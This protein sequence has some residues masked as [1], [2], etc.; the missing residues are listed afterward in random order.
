ML[1]KIQLFGSGVFGQVGSNS[2]T[3]TSS[4]AADRTGLAGGAAPG[5]WDGA[6]AEHAAASTVDTITTPMRIQ[7]APTLIAFLPW[8]LPGRALHADVE[9]APYRGEVETLAV[10]IPERHARGVLVRVPVW[11]RDSADVGPVL[12]RDPHATRAGR[13][14]VAVRIHTHRVSHQ[15]SASTTATTTATAA[16]RTHGLRVT[17]TTAW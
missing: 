13:E 3:G 14:E 12:G 10:G 8:G 16:W 1:P 9:H 7:D 2:N 11:C 17:V 6:C 5:P 15:A 4:G